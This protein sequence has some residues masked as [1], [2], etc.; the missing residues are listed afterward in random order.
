MES[1]IDVQRLLRRQREIRQAMRQPGGVRITQ[2]RELYAIYEQLRSI[3]AV[4]QML[5]PDGAHC[6]SMR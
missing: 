2:E 4:T 1:R 6:V 3:P 5:Q